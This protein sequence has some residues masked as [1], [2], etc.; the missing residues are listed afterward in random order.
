MGKHNIK[1]D[2]VTRRLIK[3]L[4]LKNLI[5]KYNLNSIFLNK[6]YKLIDF[7]FFVK[8]FHLNSS[9]ARVVNTC[10]LTGRSR[11]VLQRF[12]LSRMS[13]KEIADKGLFV[14]VKRASW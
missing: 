13:F 3:K 11:W 14:G 12:K 1:K 2:I 5:L 8:N 6:H 10:S 9:I 7:Y 4:E